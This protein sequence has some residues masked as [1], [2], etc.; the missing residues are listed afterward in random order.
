MEKLKEQWPEKYALDWDNVGLLVGRE[1]KEVHKVFVCLDVTEETLE[2]ASR[3]EA[4]MIISHHPMIFSAVKKITDRDFLGRKILRLAAEDISYYAMHTNFDVM[5]MAALNGESLGLRNSRVLEVTC[6]DDV[7][8][9]GIGRAGDLPEEMTLKELAE[10]VKERL[11]IPQVLVYGD[12]EKRISR[13]AISGGSGKSMVKPALD[14]NVQ[15]LITGDIDYHGGIDAVASGLCIID[16]GHYGT[17]YV[18]ISYMEEKLHQ[19]FPELE[20]KGARIH[21]PFQTV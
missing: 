14:R 4:D 1:E 21:F 3:W 13:A 7:R 9:E 18:F 16:A 17:E 5:G 8:Q 19:M 20:I 6:Q 15:V 12:L 2:Q 10:Y 11:K